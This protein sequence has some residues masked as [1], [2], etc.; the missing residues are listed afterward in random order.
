MLCVAGFLASLLM[1]NAAEK[2]T[3]VL[4]KVRGIVQP[5]LPLE[6]GWV[7]DATMIFRST[8]R[9]THLPCIRM[10]SAWLMP[11]GA[12]F[13][14]Q[15]VLKGDVRFKSV[16]ME[17]SSQAS[18]QRPHGLVQDRTY[19][20]FLKPGEETLKRMRETDATWLRV[21][22]RGTEV[23]A[24]LDLSASKA[25]AE[26]AGVKA[27]KSGTYDGFHFTPKKWA[28]LRA[29]KRI[30]LEVQ[31][32]LVPFLVNVVL[33]KSA[34]LVSVRSY[35]GPPDY[36]NVG[37]YGFDYH[38]DF[39]RGEHDADGEI[40][41]SLRVN[42]SPDLAMAS[43]KIEFSRCNVERGSGLIGVSWSVLSKEEH[44]K[45]GL[46]LATSGNPPEP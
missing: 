11:R 8:Y 4:A 5:W 7:T 30:D 2:E 40:S 29:S 46:P 37:Q 41:G 35:L 25:E 14:V 10:G 3:D 44:K 34:T 20:V 9:S 36:Y 24:V 16:V 28:A 18:Q 12:Q 19:L 42:F 27:T 31:K 43:Y 23:V 13:T 45:L 26:A 17:H 39:N 33:T 1:A 15:E 6:E 38:Y 32:K 21:F 22:D